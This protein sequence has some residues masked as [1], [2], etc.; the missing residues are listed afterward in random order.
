LTSQGWVDP[1]PGPLLL[2]KSGSAGNRTWDLC[3]CSQKLW[4]IDS[5]YFFFKLQAYLFS[6]IAQIFSANKFQEA[7]CK[8]SYMYINRYQIIFKQDREINFPFRVKLLAYIIFLILEAQ[9]L[10]LQKLFYSTY[11]NARQCVKRRRYT[12]LGTL[13]GTHRHLLIL[14]SCLALK[15]LSL[16][17]KTNILVMWQYHT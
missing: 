17:Y 10:F 1:V 4:P 13:C 7:H 11:F 6:V 5:K 14:S 8:D 15:L 16:W 12:F 9:K 2:R 3:I